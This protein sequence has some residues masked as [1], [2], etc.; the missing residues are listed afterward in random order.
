MTK[1]KARQK[2]DKELD[3][4]EKEINRVYS[5]NPALISVQKE[6]AKYMGMVQKRTESLYKAYI[7]ES[8]KNIKQEKKEAYMAELRALTIESSEYKK[9]IKKVANAITETNKQALD[10]VNDAMQEVYV[11][12][13]NQVAEECEKVGIKVNGK[14]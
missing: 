8:D 7:D 1:D 4:M 9:L 12:N 10:I 6:Y 5:K 11:M 14:K 13:Y 3:I 2:T